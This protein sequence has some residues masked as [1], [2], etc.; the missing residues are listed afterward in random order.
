MS[1][2]HSDVLIIDADD[3]ESEESIIES[4]S[5]LGSYEEDP[6]YS[7]STRK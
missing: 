1:S 6:E 4:S 2:T 3:Y 7:I 5:G